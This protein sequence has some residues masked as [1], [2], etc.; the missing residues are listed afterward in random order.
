MSLNY[1]NRQTNEELE[2]IAKIWIKSFKNISLDVFQDACHLHMEAS[3][4]FPTLKEILDCCSS[5][6]EKRRREV[7]VLPEPIPLLT[8]EQVKENAERVRKA[9]RLKLL[10]AKPTAEK[11]DLKNHVKKKLEKYK[12]G[13]HV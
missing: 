12:E 3:E 8:P 1:H 11:Q 7:K 10:P 13:G 5:V 6:W 9:M 4:Y 2:E